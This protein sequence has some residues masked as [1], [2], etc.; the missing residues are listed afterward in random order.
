MP[1]SIVPNHDAGRVLDHHGHLLL[2]QGLAQRDHVAL[3]LPVEV[4]HHLE[5]S[6]E[7]VYKTLYVVKETP[8]DTQ[9]AEDIS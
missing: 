6:A 3:V 2:R 8:F 4:V 7:S 5:K 9:S 1:G